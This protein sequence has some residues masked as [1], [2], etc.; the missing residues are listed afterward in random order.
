MIE[1]PIEPPDNNGKCYTFDCDCSAK[2]KVTVYADDLETAME[3][4]NLND[5]DEFEIDTIKVECINNYE[6]QDG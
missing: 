4:C 2:V 3:N 5:C 6:V 1:R